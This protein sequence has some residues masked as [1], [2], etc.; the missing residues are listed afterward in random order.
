MLFFVC[1]LTMLATTDAKKALKAIAGEV[2]VTAACS[3]TR[4]AAP[5]PG[6]ETP[7]KGTV[8]M[9]QP[10]G[11]STT[12]N[13]NI[14]GLPPE[15]LHGFHIHEFGDIATKGCQSTG[16]HYNPLH[17]AH[18]GPLDKVRHV[19]DLGNLISNR[20]GV[21]I[22]TLEDPLVSLVGPFSVIGRAF[23]IHEKIDDLGR[24]P[25]PE[26]LKTGNAGARLGCG[27]IY[28]VPV[29]LPGN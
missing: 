23:V 16:D 14:S 9:K 21:V 4:N 24:G 28:H 26:T 2:V 1:G 20:E 12:M 8:E 22:M 3:I 27:V 29:K 25:G 19:G 18:G 13:I 6:T 17:M 15:T 5:P 11:G 7:V 10:I